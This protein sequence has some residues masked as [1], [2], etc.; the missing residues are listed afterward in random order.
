[1]AAS[2]ELYDTQG[3]VMA[4]IA[5]RTARPDA[6]MGICVGTSRRS[7]VAMRHAAVLAATLLLVPIAVG[8][9]YAQPAPPLTPEAEPQPT[10]GPTP[11]DPSARPPTTEIG[12]A[13]SPNPP[14]TS[15][16][17]AA[18]TTTPSAPVIS[19]TPPVPTGWFD[20]RMSAM[21]VAAVY[22]VF[23]TWAYFAWFRNASE[24]PFFFET[25]WAQENPFALRTYAGGADKW[26]HGWA[27]YALTRGTTELLVTGGWRRVPSSIVAA[28]L[29]GA[30]FTVQELK[31]GPIWG[32]EVG[33]L[34]TDL[35]GAALAVVMEDL[36]TVDR[37]LDFR[38]RYF[39]SADFRK[40][41]GAKFWSRGD[42]IDFAQDYS[43]MSFQLALHLGA[44]PGA[45][46]QRWLSWMP[47]VDVIAGFETRG[48]SPAPMPR[49]H[50]P[51]QS[52]YLAVG[53]DMQ[54]VFDKLIRPGKLR[55]VGHGFFEVLSLPATELRIGDVRRTWTSAPA[56]PT[57]Q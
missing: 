17:V 11:T 49:V 47:W 25:K 40:L 44:L 21:S 24:R 14:P 51:Y 4:A 30:A 20:R 13:T 38:L 8:P 50:D 32:F 41:A 39:P 12:P 43:G 46:T 34:A 19:R 22:G 10:A 6:M 28:G 57:V 15:Q 23:G 18:A 5:G 7:A 27:S 31:D 53:I 36:P 3:S 37:L 52:W 56:M 55:A 35:L 26:G 45:T 2:R 9:A 1:M 54:T 16:G 48:Y 42:G 33:D 29:A